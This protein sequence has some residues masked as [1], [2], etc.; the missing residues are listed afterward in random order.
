MRTALAAGLRREGL[1]RGNTI[2]AGEV[3]DTVV[4]GRLVDDP[5]PD[6]REGFTAMLDS[7]LPRKRVIAQG[8]MRDAAGRVLLCEP[9]YKRDWDLPGGVVDPG[10]PPRDC[11]AR[12]ISEELALDVGVGRLLA[13]NW[14]SP[15]LGWGDAM[16]FVYEVDVPSQGALSRIRLLEREIRAVHW[17]SA[18]DVPGRVAPYNERMLA[19]LRAAVAGQ[20]TLELADGVPVG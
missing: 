11:V 7:V 14:L 3:H 5:A 19:S 10:E 17:T 18:A 4:L 15:W 16:L 9:V 12:E 2:L 20:G 8:L 1:L 13:T 6:S